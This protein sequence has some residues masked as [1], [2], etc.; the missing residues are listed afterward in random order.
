[1]PEGPEVRRITDR[2]NSF[3]KDTTLERI[4]V[5]VPRYG[6]KQM[7]GEVEAFMAALP[8][9]IESV[10]CKGK[11]IY[12]ILEGGWTVWN[13]LGM[14]G[15]WRQRKMPNTMLTFHTSSGKM[16]YKDARRFGTFRF[17]SS[18]EELE[19]KLSSL[20]PDMLAEDVTDEDFTAQMR[21]YPRR[22]VVQ[23]LMDQ[24][25]VSGVGN[26]IKAEA[27]YRAGISP[28]RV[29]S[30]LTDDE[31]RLLNTEVKWVI[32]ASYASRGARI[33]TYELPDGSTGE[34]NFQFQVYRQ[35]HDPDG[36][37]VIR[38]ETRDKRTTHW[39][40]ERQH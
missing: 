26:Y 16:H 37:V 1:M 5:H 13:T 35:S 15:T 18:P 14:S 40:P 3:F 28:H 9:Q 7:R 8:L 33:L 31:L 23:S 34:Y 25:V 38:E 2:I 32:R 17:S 22:T 19:A 6:E 11:F 24:K 12:F 27:L 21:R 10:Q 29:N 20:G 4:E 30:T 36:H 39:V